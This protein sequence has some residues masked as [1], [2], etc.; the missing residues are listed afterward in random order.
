MRT[1]R[2]LIET[3]AVFILTTLFALLPVATA[4][5]VGGAIGR[6]IGP[7]LAAS[8]KA[9]RHIQKIWPDCP[10]DRVRSIIAGMWDNLGRTFAEYPHLQGIANTR[11]VFVNPD[12][13][14]STLA[15]HGHA[16]FISGHLGNWEVCTAT[17]H[18]VFNAPIHAIYRAPNNP[19]LTRLLDRLRSLNG[20][21]ATI[22]KSATGARDIIKAVRNKE[23]LALLIDQKYN[24]GIAA[25][26]LG[27]M[28]MTTTAPV[29]NAQKYA[30]PIIPVRCVRLPDCH[31]QIEVFP[32]IPAFT[33]NGTPRPELDVTTDM[34]TLLGQW[35]AERPEQWIWLHR[36]WSSQKVV[37]LPR[38]TLAPPLSA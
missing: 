16:F 28:A 10:P 6:T 37:D 36:R 31:F 27:W 2:Y 38:V 15:T 17:Y 11:S 29:A 8:R 3:L 32:P 33:P 30:M 23:S 25:P 1:A 14:R 4:S 22:P 9:K 26:F 5:S 34:N 20:R 24:Q 18:A 35:I 21:I 12:I 19:Y 7:K 13:I